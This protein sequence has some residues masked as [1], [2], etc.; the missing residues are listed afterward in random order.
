MNHGQSQHLLEGIEVPVAV[1]QGMSFSHAEGSD[2][3]VNRLSNRVS[4]L[5]EP[6]EVLRRQNGKVFPAGL[7]DFAPAKL[8]QDAGERAIIWNALQHLAKDK[9]CQAEPLADEFQMEPVRLTV[10]RAA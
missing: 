5:A 7:K 10:P 2:Q 4:L 8:S 3:A 9:I 6:S 1:Q